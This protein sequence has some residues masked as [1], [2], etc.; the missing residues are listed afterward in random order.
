M[1]SCLTNSTVIVRYIK[2]GSNFIKHPDHIA[3]GG[4]LETSNIYLTL[5]VNKNGS[6]VDPL[7]EEERTFL[8]EKLTMKKGTL[9]PHN[10]EYWD[11]YY[12]VLSK[13][14]ALFNMA[15]PI[16]YIKLKVLESN[17]NLVA[18]SLDALT[19]NTKASYRYVVI[20]QGDED[21]KANANITKK[22]KCYM[23]F[24]KIEGDRDKLAYV[25]RA[26]TG[27]AV[28]KNTKLEALSASV[29][30]LI[31]SETDTFYR[32]CSDEYFDTKVLI[33]KGVKV[34]AVLRRD[35]EYF[36]PENEPLCEKG[37]NSTLEKAAEYLNK[38][39]Y[40]EVKFAIETRIETARE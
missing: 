6:Y 17:R 20:N 8:E 31:E 10:K 40:Q 35:G 28:A 38:P 11:N 1:K 25:T 12:V 14:D 26:I 39:E 36:T 34:G 5:A 13:H 3:Y 19:T 29:G 16:D 4:L 33:D 22:S 2:K 23:L 21:K 32:I 9:S 15:D 37:D 24:G 27:R 30:Q 7:S 18:H